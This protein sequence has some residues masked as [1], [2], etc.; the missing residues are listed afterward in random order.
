[1]LQHFELLPPAQ[2]P[3][4][5]R[6]AGNLW[7]TK[8]LAGPAASSFKDRLELRQHVGLE[9]I[10]RGLCGVSHLEPSF[11]SAR[12]VFLDRCI[13]NAGFASTKAEACDPQDL[14]ARPAR[15]GRGE[16]RSRRQEQALGRRAACS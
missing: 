7:S 9:K 6:P 5:P 3:C 13:A 4:H 10:F 11:S 16:L 1:M 12:V 2:L 14:P 15:W 8:D